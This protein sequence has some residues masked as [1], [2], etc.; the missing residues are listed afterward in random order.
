[1]RLKLHRVAARSLGLASIFVFA[2]APAGAR[3]AAAQ[4][5]GQLDPLPAVRLVP[6]ADGFTRPLHVT[7]AGDG[8][9]RLFI[10][11]QEGKVWIV[12]DGQVLP[13]PFLDI[14]DKVIFHP[15]LCST[16]GLLGLAFPPDY[17]ESGYFVVGYTTGENVAFPVG[18]EPDA[19]NDSVIA[20]FRVDPLDPNRADAASEEPLLLLNQPYVDHNNGMLLYGPDGM[21]Y[22]GFGDGGWVGAPQADPLAYGQR[23][24]TLHGK[25]LRIDVGPAG[26]YSVPAGNPFY[27]EAG[28]L[29]EIWAYGLRN[30]W[31]FSFDRA[32]GDFYMGDVGQSRYEEVNFRPAGEQGGEN[33]GWSITEATHCYPD[34]PCEKTGIILPIHEYTTIVDGDS[35]TGGYVYRGPHMPA[36]NGAYVY[37]DF[38]S[39]RIWALRRDG[40]AWV[41]EELLDTDLNIPAF[42]EDEAGELYLL[43]YI[44]GAL[45]QIVDRANDRFLPCVLAEGEPEPP[46]ARGR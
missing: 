25:I 32:T 39:G 31:R 38:V 14:S 7:H 37:A 33:Y 22:A 24:D 2:L 15:E 35:V 8:S 34:D 1:M 9:N 13:E 41:N 5:P 42:G 43:D 29:A 23:R 16:C 3:P 36:M 4:A 26:P 6:I 44:G 11:E 17:E 27:G 20:R 45:Y 10:L 28:V 21:L 46:P 30:P 40:P 18:K 12:Q 19:G